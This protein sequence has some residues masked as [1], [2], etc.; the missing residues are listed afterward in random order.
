MGLT[1]N[2]EAVLS[3]LKVKD[4]RVSST[5]SCKI[6]IPGRYVQVN[7]AQLGTEIYILGV[8]ALVLETGEY[9]VSSILSLVNI[10]PDKILRT[11]I[12]DE[13]YYEFWFDAGS[14]IIA[15]TE[16]ILRDTILYS[17]FNEFIISGRIPWFMNYEDV[18]KL[19]NTAKEYAGSS[20]G[21][22]YEIWEFLASIIARSPKD[23]SVFYRLGQDYKSQPQYVSLT[24]FFYSI[25]STTNKLAGNYFTD[26]LTSALV[27]P[28]QNVEKIEQLLRA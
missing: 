19:F 6:Q 11:K 14:T 25:S 12:N 22:T 2:P 21:D 5:V 13:E 1:R 9:A 15:N 4:N 20:I 24:S 18:G 16:L 8:Y 3:K 28:S 27:N 7:L 23:R 26:G 17:I 10:T